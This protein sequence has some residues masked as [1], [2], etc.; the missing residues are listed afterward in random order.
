MKS[1][2]PKTSTVS[3][4]QKNAGPFFGKTEETFFKP[5]LATK[6]VGFFA[7]GSNNPPVNNSFVQTKLKTDSSEETQSNTLEATGTAVQLKCTSCEDE[8]KMIQREEQPNTSVTKGTETNPSDPTTPNP[9]GLSPRLSKCTTDPQFPDFPCLTRALKLDIDE[10]LWNNAPQ[11]YRVATLYPGDSKLMLD[12]FMRYGV[13]VNLLKTGFGFAGADKKTANIL[14]YGT[15]IALK[16][17]DFL[18]NGVIK[19]DVPIPLGKGVNLDLKFD[20]NT[21]PKNP[22]N[23]QGVNTQ[24][25]ISGHF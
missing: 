5:A 25:G 8:N 22:S 13:G 1:A 6:P 18:Q 3:I 11:F 17:Y 12:T 9:T 14:S 10:N 15:G 4:Q 16:S 23:V 7:T 19:L 20:L 21:D 24:V 2:E